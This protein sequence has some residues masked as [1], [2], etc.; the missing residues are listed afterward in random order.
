MDDDLRGVLK[1]KVESA[2]SPSG[3]CIETCRY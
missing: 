3:K 2:I 1:N